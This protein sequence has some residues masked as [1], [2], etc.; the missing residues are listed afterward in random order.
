MYI[1][2]VLLVICVFLHCVFL[3]YCVWNIFFRVACCYSL[4]F[5]NIYVNISKHICYA[6]PKFTWQK[7]EYN[8]CWS[9]VDIE[10]KTQTHTTET[11]FFCFVKVIENRFLKRDWKWEHCTP[12]NCSAGYLSSWYWN[13]AFA[14]DQKGRFVF[15]FY[16]FAWMFFSVLLF[17]LF[18]SLAFCEPVSLCFLCFQFL[19]YSV[20]QSAEIHAGPSTQQNTVRGI[21]RPCISPLKHEIN[22]KKVNGIQLV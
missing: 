11:L 19:W 3:L 13:D 2:W 10:I 22:V 12:T 4:L 17:Y 1:L 6:F 9:S 20:I 16:L 7:T 14:W 21:Y 5:V 18:F 15:C 8:I